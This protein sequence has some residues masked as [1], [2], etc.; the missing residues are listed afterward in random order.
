MVNVYTI[1]GTSNGILILF[2]YFNKIIMHADLFWVYG[3]V[4]FKVYWHTIAVVVNS[5]QSL[6]SRPLSAVGT[7]RI[8]IIR[9][10]L[11]EYTCI[12]DTRI[13]VYIIMLHRYLHREARLCE[14]FYC[15]WPWVDVLHLDK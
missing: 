4:R 11:E 10:L 15:M 6:V 5:G 3:V 14:L 2:Y 7:Y 8:V 13:Y 12:V 9:I 1:L